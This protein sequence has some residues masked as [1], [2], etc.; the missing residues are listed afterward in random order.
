MLNSIVSST[1]KGLADVEGRLGERVRGL[2]AT[3]AAILSAA[4]Q[5]SEALVSR[6]D[7]IR[8]ASGDLLSN[9]QS[10]VEA[11]DHRAQA[12]RTLS[13]EISETQTGLAQMLGERQ[14]IFE[15]LVG[16]LNS[17]I[18]D[19]DAMLRSF[20]SLVEDQ[21]STAEA[22][23]REASSLVHE[24]AETAAQAIGSQYERIRLETGKERERTAAALR[25]AYDQANSELGTLLQSGLQGFMATAGD[26][27]QATR[28]ILADLEATRAALQAGG[29]EIPARR[30]RQAR[31]SSAWWATSSVPSPN[32]TRSSRGPARPWM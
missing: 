13:G 9:S 3:L 12:M 24:S 31:T 23:A 25:Q 5:G 4:N 22:R 8:T 15:N 32:S 17:R 6:V 20:T 19:V 30:A 14:Q 27:R 2:E 10:A 28:D 7:A 29:L 1:S 18:E 26:L 21:L 11:L 16:T